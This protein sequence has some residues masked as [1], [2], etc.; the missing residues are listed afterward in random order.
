MAASKPKQA[1][2]FEGAMEELEKIVQQLERGE[3]PLEDALTSFKQG[4]ELSQFCQETLT[5]A[6]ETVAQIMT[7][8]GPVDFDPK[9]G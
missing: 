3:L 6:E 8:K 4:I 2:N 9:A 7:P 1:L 5:K